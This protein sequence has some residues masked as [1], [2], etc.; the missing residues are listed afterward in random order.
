MPNDILQLQTVKYG[1]C[2]N[3]ITISVE[4]N[5][6]CTFYYSAISVNQIIII[7]SSNTTDIGQGLP[8]CRHVRNFP[9]CFATYV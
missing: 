5:W 1:T 6:Q 3:I 8:G 2:R 4:E 7:V 9:K